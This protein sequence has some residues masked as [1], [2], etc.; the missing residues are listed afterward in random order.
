MNRFRLVSLGLL[1]L[2]VAGCVEGEVTY[3]VNPDGSARVRVDVVT[4]VPLN[5]VQNFAKKG[6]KDPGEETLDQLLREAIRPTLESPGVVAWKD[7]SARFLPDGKLKFAGTA[8]VKRIDDFDTKG[9]LP[10]FGPTFALERGA[11]G[12]LKLVPGKEEAD[13]PLSK[14]RKPKTPDEIKKMTDAEL[15]QYI[16]RDL[17]QLQSAKPL[18]TAFFADTKLKTTFVMPGDLTAAAGLETDGRKATFVLDGNK[19]LTALNKALKQSPAEWRNMYRALGGADAIQA[20]V[21]GFSPQTISLTVARPGAAQ[22]DFLK[23]VKE[24]R[25]GYPELR[26]KFGF[27]DDL[28][29]PTDDGVPKK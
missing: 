28:R 13:D 25:A 9:G 23:E 12:S 24:A 5:P 7:V 17:I 29:L 10:L 21:L 15:D 14:K 16:L 26:K 4:V 3:T 6:A 27:G 19:A 22:F 2:L 8:Y 20:S 11:D 1:C 18:F